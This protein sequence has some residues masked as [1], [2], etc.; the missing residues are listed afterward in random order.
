MLLSQQ[1]AKAQSASEGSRTIHQQFLTWVKKHRSFLLLLLIHP[2]QA[3]QQQ[4][5]SE[6]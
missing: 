5:K 4:R 3:G 1:L 6:H 2:V